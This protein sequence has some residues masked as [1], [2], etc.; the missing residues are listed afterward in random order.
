MRHRIDPREAMAGAAAECGWS[1]ATQRNIALNYIASLV[2]S[3]P[4]E[5]E[6]FQMFLDDLCEEEESLSIE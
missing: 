1:D 6:R 3:D 2:A 4:T 5:G